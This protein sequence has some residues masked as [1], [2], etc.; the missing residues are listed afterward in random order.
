MT[1]RAAVVLAAAL[2]AP[3][4]AEAQVSVAFVAPERFTDAENRFGSG[5][6]LR[7]TLAEI[8][9]LF[10]ELG[11]RVLR[12]G[13]SLAITVLDIDLAGYER[14]VGLPNS[15]RIVSDVA[16][17]RLRLRYVLKERGRTVL[18]GEE[19]VT[20]INFLTRYAR[21]FSL[22]L[23]LRARADTGLA[24]GADRAA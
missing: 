5:P 9:R 6:T 21:S 17:P 20:D 24:P 19:V 7:V 22:Q 8:R 16:P 14:P 1:I 10:T 2:L 11:D 12:P 23:H 4:P 18:S 13:E 3:L 15:P